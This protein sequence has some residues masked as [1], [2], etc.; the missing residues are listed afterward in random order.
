MDFKNCTHTNNRWFCGGIISFDSNIIGQFD[1]SLCPLYCNMNLYVPFL[2]LRDSRAPCCYI[3]RLA[4]LP[5]YGL[6]Y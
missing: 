4:M 6:A 3:S 2:N 1:K 5:D